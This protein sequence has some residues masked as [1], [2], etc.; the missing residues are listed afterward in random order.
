[1]IYGITANK[2]QKERFVDLF[3]DSKPDFIQKSRII[4]LGRNGKSFHI[5]LETRKPQEGEKFPR[6]LRHEATNLY[7]RSIS[8]WGFPLLTFLKTSQ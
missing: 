4:P 5:T 3:W 1:M 2:S 7:F 8:F 6:I